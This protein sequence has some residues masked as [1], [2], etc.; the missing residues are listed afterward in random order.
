MTEESSSEAPCVSRGLRLLGTELRIPNFSIQI[1]SDLSVSADPPQIELRTDM[2]SYWLEDAI[3]AASTAC[4]I[5]DPIPAL[6]A[7]LGSAPDTAAVEAKIDELMIKELRASMRA[8]TG[9]AFAMDGF[10][11]V[12]KARYG[13]H[14]DE[15]LWKNKGTPRKSRI[16]ETIRR[17]LRLTTP[18]AR[19]LKDCVSRVFPYRDWAVHMASR[20]NEPA[21][22]ADAQ[23]TIDWHFAA[24]RHANAVSAVTATVVVLNEL[25]PALDRRSKDLADCKR[26]SRERFDAAMRTYASL[27]DLPVLTFTQG[28]AQL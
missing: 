17:H 10:Y 26:V 7:S 18:E 27:P 12:V 6:T 14:P 20:F 16:T 25:I 23:V 15:L 3:E 5:A 13:P 24:F 9:A 2:W 11:G 4:R 8:I 19:R 21:Y 28:L 1:S 22:R